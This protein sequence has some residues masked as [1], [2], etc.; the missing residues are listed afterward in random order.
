MSYIDA[1]KEGFRVVHRNWQL[2]LV[3][4]G[5]VI[6]SGIGFFVLVGIP[7]AIAFI[8]FGIDLTE[9]T[10]IKDIFK[11]LKEPSEIISKYF[12]L[13]LIVIAGLLMY[14][15]IAAIFTIYVFGGSIG[16]IGRALRDKTP[17]FTMN[18]FF[19]EAKRLFLPMLGFTAVI[20]II[21][22]ATAFVLGIFGGGVTAL[23][24]FVKS[25]D[26]TLALFLGTFFSLILIIIALTLLLGILS[27]TMYGVAAL[28][29]KG[30]GPVKS[31]KEA[32]NYVVR[33]PRAFWLYTLLFGGYVLISFLLI[34]LGYPFKL[35]PV[36][37]IVL[38][39]PYQLISYA[40]QT[41]IGLAVIAII[42]TY[43]YSTGIPSESVVEGSIPQTPVQ[44]GNTIQDS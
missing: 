13:V 26:S 8:I 41:Y 16:V 38:S 14:I 18:I 35:V 7:L 42:F 6:L 25:Q 43:Y 28:S 15:L 21:L 23:V 4:L 3:Q 5:M 32:I 27:I 33:H 36:I 12:G 17:K 19:S 11:L 22:I 44:E 20:G 10:N 39:F 1:I 9:I 2:V 40:F 31:L 29:I 37:G 24:S 34:L 30:I